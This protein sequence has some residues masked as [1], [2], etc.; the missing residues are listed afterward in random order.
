MYRV[1]IVR[2]DVTDFARVLVRTGKVPFER[3][4]RTV[5]CKVCISEEPFAYP[6]HY[7]TRE[8]IAIKDRRE[9]AEQARE[10]WLTE[11]PEA[12]PD[13]WHILIKQRAKFR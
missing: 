5:F 7:R 13:G 3:G 9:D 10:D 11:H 12:T 6:Y 8:T 4:F 2:R 1:D